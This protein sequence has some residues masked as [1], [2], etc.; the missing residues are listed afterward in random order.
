MMS[1]PTD[2]L[3]LFAV[4]APFLA[5]PVLAFAGRRLGERT[6]WLALPVPLLACAAI[7][8]V[9]VQA[10]ERPNFV[11]E[12]R[13]IPSLGLNLSFLIDGLSLFFGLIVSGVGALIVFYGRHYLDNHYAHHGRF[14]ACLLLFMGAMLGT[15]FANHLLL[16]FVFWELTGIASFLLIGFSHESEESQRGARMA[17]LVTGATGLCLLVGVVLTG[18]LTGTHSLQELLANPLPAG[19]STL[20][21]VALALLLLGAFGKSAQ[22]PFQFWLPNAMAAPTPVSAY[23]HSATM[24]KLGVFLCARLFPIFNGLDWWAP[25]VAGVG[26]VTMTLA[27]LKA[28][29][30]FD[31]KA[32][33]AWTTVSQLG[34]LIAQY[35]L[36][37]RAGLSH[38]YLH[39]LNH[40]L[41]K[42]C[43]FMVVGAI[44]HATGTRDLRQLGGLW[45]RDRLLGGITLVAC[46]SMAGLPFTTGF[47]SKEA[48]LAE[49]LTGAQGSLG[50]FALGCVLLTSVAK[51]VFSARVFAG[52]FLGRETATVKEH[53]HR[54]GR[55][56]LVPPLLLALAIPVLG[57]FP[58]LLDGPLACLGVRGLHAAEPAHLALWHGFTRE[59]AFSA[60]IVA[61]GAL[62]FAGLNR[63]GWHWARVP[64]W[65]Q[66]DLAFEALVRG[67]GTFAKRVTR[68]AGSDTPPVYLR[69]ILAFACLLIGGALVASIRQPEVN[70]L[71]IRA[72]GPEAWQPLRAL[73]AGLIALATLGCVTLRAWP[74]QLISLSLAGFL[75]TFYYVHYRAPDLALTQILVETV[76]LVLVLL[77]LGRFPRA[78]ELG[79]AE[80]QRLTGQQF[81]RFGIALGIGALMTTLLLVV[82]DRPHPEPIGPWYL[83]ATRP[84]AKGDN[85]VNTILVDFRGFDTLFEAAVLVIATLGCL[86]LLLRYKRT[87]AEWRQAEKGPPGFGLGP[88]E[89]TE[90]RHDFP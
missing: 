5:A 3:L 57:V 26:L 76:S 27:A 2:W 88:A 12:W 23:L 90:R 13:W 54:P 59:L 39:I 75:T 46:A 25:L 51:I 15:V 67:T 1:I 35:G 78:C 85:A 31:L 50:T 58:G 86:G 47:I 10:G 65:A 6:G 49:M 80:D 77:L 21:N 70:G 11:V 40:V 63:T 81:L 20:A 41:Y 19:G 64:R 83:E 62:V 55:G 71:L 69:I 17:L 84:L 72:A 73:T 14:Y 9:A 18:Q 43:L 8:A 36:A 16:L 56:L 7:L 87:P 89:T 4:L 53:F 82:T 44:D 66:F 28:L 74:A 24:V 68:L 38:D 61:V 45:R 32:V 60:G 48:T 30:V 52:A 37:E 29:L 33:L 42:G 22:F 34:A 79:E